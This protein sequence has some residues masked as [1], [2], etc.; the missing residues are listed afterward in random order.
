MYPPG[1]IT[2]V[3]GLLESAASSAFTELRRSFEARVGLATEVRP[4]GACTCSMRGELF[5]SRSSPLAL[6]HASSHPVRLAG[7]V[8]EVG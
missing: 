6:V 3:V 5:L 4:S 8:T 2:N 1:G 7:T